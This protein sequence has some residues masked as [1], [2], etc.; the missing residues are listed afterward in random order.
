MWCR[1]AG[2]I[3]WFVDHLMITGSQRTTCRTYT[4]GR[5]SGCCCCRP[6]A[7]VSASPG[8]CFAMKTSKCKEKNCH[9]YKLTENWSF[10]KIFIISFSCY[11][12]NLTWVVQFKCHH[13]HLVCAY[14]TKKVHISHMGLWTLFILRQDFP[15]VL[16]ASRSNAISC[17]S[18]K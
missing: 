4:N 18:D 10:Q 12:L 16:W 7:S 3:Y 1:H 14:D 2:Y 11:R 8:W 17:L 9:V 6:S 13:T 5:R 15:D